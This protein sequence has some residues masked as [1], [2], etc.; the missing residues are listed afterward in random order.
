M[1]LAVQNDPPRGN[2]SNSYHGNGSHGNGNHGNRSRGTP[3]RR[4]ADKR[5]NTAAHQRFV[6]MFSAV[7]LV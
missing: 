5:R 2:V 7:H 6:Q 3:G 1:T 4:R